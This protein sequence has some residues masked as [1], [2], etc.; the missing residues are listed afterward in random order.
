MFYPTPTLLLPPT[1]YPLPSVH[2]CQL[3]GPLVYMKLRYKGTAKLDRW[4]ADLTV[5][6]DYA[7]KFSVSN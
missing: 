3:V 1:P 5:R 7:W 2:T 4:I 6:L